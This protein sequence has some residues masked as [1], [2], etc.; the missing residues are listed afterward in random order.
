MK[1]FYTRYGANDTW[2]EIGETPLKDVRVPLGLLR[3]KAE[4]PGFDSAEDVTPFV[5]FFTLSPTGKTPEGMVM[6][7]AGARAVLDLCVWPRNAESSVRWFLGRSVR[8]HQPP[9]QNVVDAGG[10]KRRD[11]W[12]SSFVKDGKPLTFEQTIGSFIDKTGR[13][14]P[15]TW[16]LGNYPAGAA[17][18]A[19]H[20]RQLV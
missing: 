7:G 20:R 5:P 17:D 16:E 2:R 18:L 9:V 11:W 12:A 3:F 15:A 13:P 4:K 14:G 1:V 6:G 19:R 10:Y 8:G